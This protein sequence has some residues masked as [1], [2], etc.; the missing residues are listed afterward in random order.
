MMIQSTKS[1]NKA[2]RQELLL[3]SN[4]LIENQ[5]R[6]IK[7]LEK[8][9]EEASNQMEL[10]QYPHYVSEGEERYR[11]GMERVLNLVK[12]FYDYQEDKKDEK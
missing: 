11:D 4:G 6:L 2:S 5:A 10:P 9:F 1:L 7:I 12:G 3:L 8:D